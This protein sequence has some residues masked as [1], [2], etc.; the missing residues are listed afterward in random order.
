MLPDLA[1]LNIF[2]FYLI[3]AHREA[4]QTLVHVCRQWRNIVFGLPR[5]LELQLYCTARK[6][7]REMLNIWPPLSIFI[8]E[9]G[10]E[11]WGMDHIFAVLE[12]NDRVCGVDIWIPSFSQTENV[13]ATMQQP[14]LELRHLALHV[15]GQ[16][17]PVIP[18]SFLG[19]SAPRLQRL[20]LDGF[21]FPGLPNLLLSATH[22]IYLDLSRIPDSGCFSPEAIATCL[23]AMT[24]LETLTI[25]FVFLQPRSDDISRRLP[26]QT[27]TL[28]PVLTMLCFKGDGEY[29]DDFVAR[30]DS[31]LLDNLAI[32]FFPPIFDTPQLAQF[33]SRTLK[34]KAH[35]EARVVF[36]DHA[37]SVSLR[38]LEGALELK[39]SHWSSSRQLLSVARVCSS[40]LPPSLISVVECLY[41]LN[42]SS[43]LRWQINNEDAQW[44]SLL[45]T[46]TAVKNLYIHREFVPR[47]APALQELVGE[48]VTKVLPVLQTLFIMD[49]LPPGPVKEAIGQF[50]AARQLAGHTIAVT[51]WC[52]QQFE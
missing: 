45:Q 34:F 18:T 11:T 48:R 42:Q 28:L 24:R 22:L 4:W 13:L 27:R 7:A 9:N 41:I 32:T 29:L 10:E 25:K 47:I 46:S 50:V 2:D 23:S 21:S 15:R 38:T 17:M 33:I 5:R 49:P 31:P 12:H 36:S 51:N 1:L 35:D 20:L 43:R 44:L 19:G 14:F 40:S 39:F 26:P 8:G 3:G 30:I 37:V 52:I 6:P 16:T